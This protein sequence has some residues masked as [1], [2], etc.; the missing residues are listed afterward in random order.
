MK[1]ICISR[2]LV[3]SRKAIHDWMVPTSSQLHACRQK[4]WGCRGD[5]L[6]SHR[7]VYLLPRAPKLSTPLPHSPSSTSQPIYADQ[8]SLL[9]T[10]FQLLFA[11]KYFFKYLDGA[12]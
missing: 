1:S 4:I 11:W 3:Q 9:Y 7:N 6:I 5:G 8:H 2:T 12:S 10:Y